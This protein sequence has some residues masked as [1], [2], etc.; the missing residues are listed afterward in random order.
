MSETGLEERWTLAEPAS[1]GATRPGVIF[2]HG[3]PSG[4]IPSSHVGTDLPELCERVAREMG[5]FA[6]TA[7]FRATSTHEGQLSLR[8]WVDDGVEMVEEFRRTVQPDD[9][10]LVGFGAG[11]TVASSVALV[12]AGV[13]GLALV[14][15]P[16]DFLHLPLDFD[17]LLTYA[18]ARRLVTDP[19]FPPDPD[20]WLEE[21]RAITASAAVEQL[22]DRELLVLHGADDDV[23]PQLDARLLAELHGGAELRIL[24]GA[25][26]HLRHDPRAMAILLGW[27][28][29]QRY[30]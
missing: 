25:G 15:T 20:A 1:P 2:M 21:F 4:R 14:E 23:V 5:F 8:G 16:S 27:L 11:G 12:D 9:L 17:Q 29:R 18:R 28:E 19:A 10:W 7:P 26:H 22:A 30:R 24:P 13:R 6:M 3:L